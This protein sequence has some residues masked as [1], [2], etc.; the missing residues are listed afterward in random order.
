MTRWLI[1]IA[2]CAS[3]PAAAGT[4]GVVTSEPHLASAASEWLTARGETVIAAPLDGVRAA[5]LRDCFVIEDLGCARAVVDQHSTTDAVVYIAIDREP[6]TSIA[7]HWIVKHG[8][9]T[10]RTE[11]CPG[12]SDAMVRD[13]V[14]ANLAQLASTTTPPPVRAAN[15]VATTTATPPA[16]ERGGLAL[17]VELGE[18]TSA[19]L[20]WFA[21][22]LSIGGAVGSGTLAGAGISVRAGLQL[23][24]MRLG[25]RIPLRVGLGGRLYHHGYE[26]MSIDELPD[27]HYGMFASVAAAVDRGPLQLYAEVAPGLDL[28]RSRGCTLGSGAATVCPHVQ[29]APVFVHFMVGARWFLAH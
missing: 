14:I 7:T 29:Q 5:T 19:T 28:A 18:P 16:R 23:E 20:A 15:A 8:P 27:T 26:A 25:P 21:G 17:G 12:C 24:V 1:A 13:R 4:I 6:A 22:K 2:L 3:A 9:S 11:T 10:N